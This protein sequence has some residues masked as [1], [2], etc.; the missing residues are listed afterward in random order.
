[1]NVHPRV[2]NG[3]IGYRKRP[4]ILDMY[5]ASNIQ[6]LKDIEDVRKRIN[7]YF[8]NR[9]P[10]LHEM[11]WNVV[12]EAIDQ[13]T[14]LGS[15]SIN[16]TLFDEAAVEI[17][18]NGDDYPATDYHYGK[19]TME[20]LLTG[21]MFIPGRP[22]KSSLAMK[23]RIIEIGCVNAVSRRMIVQTKHQGHLWQQIYEAWQPV[24]GVE[25]ITPLESPLETGTTIRFQPDFTIIEEHEVDF[26]DLLWQLQFLAG[27]IP[28]IELTLHDQR[29]NAEMRDLIVV[30]PCDQLDAP[31]VHE[32]LVV[33]IP[34]NDGKRGEMDVELQYHH[35]RQPSINAYFNG[36]PELQL[37]PYLLC[38]LDDLRKYVNKFLYKYSNAPQNALTLS[39]ICAGLSLDLY[40][41][42]ASDSRHDEWPGNILQGKI[43]AYMDNLRTDNP[44][45]FYR[46]IEKCL[47]N[48][49]RR[50]TR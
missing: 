44:T 31:A 10:I 14:A 39:D 33:R 45:V 4:R 13:C 49:Q 42:A 32:P 41:R 19:S 43:H 11:I 15:K 1:M 35:T 2:K 30:Q 34:L 48:R 29:I 36:L 12:G 46:V 6:V 37:R 16:I 22:Y 25:R 5:N 28:D 20:T 26:W 27:F 24:T 40:K 3:I 21:T 18:H 9:R 38:L 7:L 47:D 8:V 23:M 50:I 17:S